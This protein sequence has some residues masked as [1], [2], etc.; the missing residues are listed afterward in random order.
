MASGTSDGDKVGILVVDDQPSQLLSHEAILR[1][2]GERLVMARSGREALQRL[3]DEDF[4]VIL[5]DVNM[6]IGV[7]SNRGCW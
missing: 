5:L 6:T 1:E 2:L 7:F 3:M 4:A